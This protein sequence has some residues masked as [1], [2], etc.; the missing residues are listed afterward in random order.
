VQLSAHGL[1]LPVAPLR[2]PLDVTLEGSYS[3]QDIF[4]RNFQL[5]SER[6]SLGGFLMLG[7]NFTELQALQLTID[8]K[9]CASGTIFLPLGVNR[10]RTS[11]S[12]LSAFDDAQKFDIDL[13]I[14]HLDLT[15]LAS[16]L[17]EK[18]A[19]GGVLS[20]KLA[21]FGPLRTLQVTTNWRLENFARESPPQAIDFSAH[22]AE[23][24]MDAQ[25]TAR[26][27]VSEPITIHAWFPLRMEKTRIGNGTILD[28][29]APFSLSVEYPAL[30]LQTLPNEWRPGMERGLLSGGIYFSNSLNQPAITG[31]TQLI[32]TRVKPAPP[33]PQIEE[34]NAQIRFENTVAIIDPLHCAIGST[35]VDLRGQF[36]VGSGGFHL[37][38]EPQREEIEVT[39]APTTGGNLSTIRVSG[40]TSDATGERLRKLS[41]QGVG[42]PAAFGVTIS[43]EENSLPLGRTYFLDAKSMRGDPLL[44]RVLTPKKAEGFDLRAGQST[45]SRGLWPNE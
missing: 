34:L 38:L 33:W 21:A 29:D 8:S 27:G 39:S 18:S 40:G 20:G 41:V 7:R 42:W 35:S 44:L 16:A 2:M 14:D 10:W 6:L 26:F 13:A 5:A 24:K 4:F 19:L 15:A 36:S 17:G 30:F 32:D 37:S 31:E 28:R 22:Y 23:K 3:P 45:Q 11:G 9:P 25:A 12:W 1:Q 43:S